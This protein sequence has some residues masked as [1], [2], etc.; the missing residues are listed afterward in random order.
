MNILTVYTRQSVYERDLVK[1]MFDQ[2]GMNDETSNTTTEAPN[3]VNKIKRSYEKK[4]IVRNVPFSMLMIKMTTHLAQ[5][6]M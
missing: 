4:H 1:S 5:C 3:I 2:Y 6:V